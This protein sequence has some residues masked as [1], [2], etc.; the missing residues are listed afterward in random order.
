MQMNAIDFYKENGKII[1]HSW[2]NGGESKKEVDKVPD[3]IEG[4]KVIR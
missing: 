1:E 2:E 3:E 4:Y